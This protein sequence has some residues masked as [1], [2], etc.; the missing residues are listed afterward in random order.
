MIRIAGLDYEPEMSEAD[1]ER[2]ASA[3]RTL[4]RLTFLVFKL[5]AVRKL[6]VKRTARVCA[7]RKSGCAV[8]W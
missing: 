8:T 4:P 3:V 5:M 6:G 1:I 7:S 2:A